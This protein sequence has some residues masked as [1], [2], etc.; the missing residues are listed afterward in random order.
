MAET[1]RSDKIRTDKKTGLKISYPFKIKV[2]T[3]MYIFTNILVIG[4]F[5]IDLMIGNL[6]SLTSMISKG[7]D[8]AQFLQDNSQL[9]F[10]S[11]L[12]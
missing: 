11:F 10:T 2:Y 1:L 6:S 5:I 7:H 3:N 9:R 8:L 4:L 12:I